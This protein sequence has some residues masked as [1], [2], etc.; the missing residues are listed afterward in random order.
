MIFLAP[1]HILKIKECLLSVFS[2]CMSIEEFEAISLLSLVFCL[3]SGENE[4]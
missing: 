3:L 4:K 2:H 1:R